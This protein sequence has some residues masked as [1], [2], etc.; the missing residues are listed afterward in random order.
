ML[1]KLTLGRKNINP[2]N[3]FLIESLPGRRQSRTIRLHVG[4][5]DNLQNVTDTHIFV[6]PCAKKE[7]NSICHQCDITQFF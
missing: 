7:Q 4:V 5:L 3:L 1:V 6:N 2:L